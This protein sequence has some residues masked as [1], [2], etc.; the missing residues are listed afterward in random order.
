VSTERAA[1]LYAAVNFTAVGLSHLLQPRA[2]VEFFVWLRG[3][4]RAG[5]LANGMLSLAFGSVIVAFHDVWSPPGVVLTVVGWGQV[6]KGFLYLLVPRW[7]L[8]TMGRVAPGR[9]REIVVAGALLLVLAG[10]A[11]YAALSR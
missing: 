8:R 1:E 5:A 2:W 7:G 9:D 6:L 3:L 10:V 4:G 11:W